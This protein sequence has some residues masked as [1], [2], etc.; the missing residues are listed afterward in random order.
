M[1]KRYPFFLAG[2]LMLFLFLGQSAAQSNETL[3]SFL[4]QEK[5]S[6]GHSA[7]MILTAAGILDEET[8]VDEALAALA[9]SEVEGPSRTAEEAITLGEYS[10][11]LMQALEIRGGLMY[12]IFPGPRYAAREL[13]YL[14]LIPGDAGPG[15]SLSG[16][17]AVQ[18][19]GRALE[20]KEARS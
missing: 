4:E 2:S 17:E 20:W 16:T 11:L 8:S 6:F 12:R 13:K 7:Y 10:Y 1:K 9:G 18:I 15:R 5:A 14:D 3:D 19:L